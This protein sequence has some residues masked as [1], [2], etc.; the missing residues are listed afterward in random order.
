MEMVAYVGW[1]AAA[2]GLAAFSNAV[3]KQVGR[4]YMKK[5]H[6]RRPGLAHAYRS[7]M[8]GVVRWHPLVGAVFVA[9]A[10]VHGVMILFGGLLSLTGGCAGVLA[11]ST[12]SLGT[13]GKYRA[14]KPAGAW[15]HMHSASALMLVAAVSVHVWMKAVLVVP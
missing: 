4:E 15:I 14:V 2:A 5:M 3:V 9:L 7:F 8:R 11:L 1:T 13:Y 6:Q 12:V 10:A